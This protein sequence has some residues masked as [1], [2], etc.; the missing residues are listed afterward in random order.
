MFM[1]EAISGLEFMLK[2]LFVVYCGVFGTVKVN[3]EKIVKSNILLSE[4]KIFAI[5][6]KHLARGPSAKVQINI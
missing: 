5:L 3:M 6:T 1:S 4:F 2:V